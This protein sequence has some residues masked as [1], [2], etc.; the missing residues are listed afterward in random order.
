MTETRGRRRTLLACAGLLACVA[1]LYWQVVDH[2]LIPFDDPAYFSENHHV[3]SGL[4]VESVRWA[5]T[6][7]ERGNWHPL[8]WL[9]YMAGVELAGEKPGPHLLINAL[10][11][12]ANAV[13]LFLVLAGYTGSFWRAL[14]VAALFAVHPLR[15]ESVAWLS[16]RKDVLSAFFWL[17]S[18][19]AYRRYAGAPGLSRLWPTALL[20][21]LGLM[22]KPMLVTAPFVLVLLDYWPLNRLDASRGGA[23]GRAPAV[24][25]RLLKLLLEKTPLMVLVAAASWIAF[26]AQ[27]RGGA[28]VY[29]EYFSFA[30]RCANALL[31]C[32]RYLGKTLLPVKLSIYYPLQRADLSFAAVGAAAVLVALGTALALAV[33]RRRP[34]LAVGWLWYLGMLVPVIGLV[35]VGG[36]ALADRYTYLPQIGLLILVVWGAADLAYRYRLPRALLSL[37]A[38]AVLAVLM[39]LAWT[40]VGLWRNGGTL[41]TH[42]LQVQPRTSFALV[43][44]ALY[45]D[46]QGRHQQARPLYEEALRLQPGH[47][48]ANYNYGNL[49]IRLGRLDEGV[50]HLR[51]S[52]ERNPDSVDTLSSLGVAL[53]SRGGLVEAERFFRRALELAPGSFKTNYNLGLFL[54]DRGRGEEAERHYRRALA[55]DPGRTDAHNN[56]GILLTRQ[57]RLDEAQERFREALRLDPGNLQARENLADLLRR[58]GAVP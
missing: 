15:V 44:L 51:R 43:N 58:R 45:H 14:A 4:S 48:V 12:G 36:Q 2:E 46:V 49:L 47:S 5:F 18:L 55:I 31:S 28:M 30:E 57:G 37:C 22:A 56:L 13:L 8:T 33:A 29:M 39:G 17:L 40:Q 25:R 53:V 41:F 32:V 16:E 19:L 34:Y 9:S 10:L 27:R 21:G 50:E 6:S 35:Q 26:V 3:T 38:G 23:G 52:L 20:L 42:A 54:A 7:L 11:H 24:W 1:A